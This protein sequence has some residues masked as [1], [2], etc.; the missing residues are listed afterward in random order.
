M[1]AETLTERFWQQVM[2][3]K[4]KPRCVKGKMHWEICS[5]QLLCE[6]IS[7]P[8]PPRAIAWAGMR[9]GRGF[10]PLLMAPRGQP[11]ELGLGGT[12]SSKGSQG[13]ISP[14]S[15]WGFSCC[16][17]GLGC[18]LM[19]VLG[20]EQ[21]HRGCGFCK[22]GLLWAPRGAEPGWDE[23]CCRLGNQGIK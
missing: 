11:W 9:W 2:K 6:F 19:V 3:R 17:R 23:G 16:P 4:K 14:A 12:C 20:I 8:A 5:A 22:V 13:S 15:F 21:H 7:H 10:S 18:F 1:V